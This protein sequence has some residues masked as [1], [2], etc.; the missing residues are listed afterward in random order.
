MAARKK[1]FEERYIPEPN[2]GCW[3]WIGGVDTKG[4]GRVSSSN[5]TEGPCLAHRASYELAHGPIPD[6]MFVCHKCDTPCCVN[7]SHLFLGTAKDN[8]QDMVRKGRKAPIPDQRGERA[9]ASKLTDSQARAILADQRR[10]RLIAADYGVSRS[11]IRHIKYGERFG[12]L[13]QNSERNQ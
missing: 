11:A 10:H 9:Y 4:Y 3:L 5:T 6:G 1:T 8:M 7:P 2:S 12:H 13:K